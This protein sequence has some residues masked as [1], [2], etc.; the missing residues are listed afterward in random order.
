MVFW[1]YLTSSGKSTAK[2]LTFLM[3]FCV[4]DVSF[5]NHVEVQGVC[6][7]QFSTSFVNRAF[8]EKKFLMNSL[9][10]SFC[11]ILMHF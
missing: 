7:F 11:T 5:T 6:F 10:S 9:F 1:Y 2:V 3:V 4:F 8:F